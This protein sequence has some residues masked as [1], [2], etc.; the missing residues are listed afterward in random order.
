M[1][2]S[3]KNA[4][5]FYDKMLDLAST[6][7]RIINPKRELEGGTIKGPE[8]IVKAFYRDDFHISITNQ[9]QTGGSS[10]VKTLVDQASSFITGRV[11]KMATHYMQDYL[12]KA[13]SADNIDKD[14]MDWVDK[15]AS[16]ISDIQGIQNSAFF[17]ADDYFKSFKGTTVTFPTNI[18]LTLVSDEWNPDKENDVFYQ[19]KK[20]M[21]VSIGDYST[22]GIIG[23]VGIQSA[24]NDFRTGGMELKDD[25]KGTLVVVYGDPERGGYRIDNMV[26]SNLHFTF[27]KTK[28]QIGETT[29]EVEE[30][31]PDNTKTKKKVTTGIFR[32]LYIDIQIMLEPAQKYTK[33]DVK[34]TLGADFKSFFPPKEENDKVKKDSATEDKSV[35]NEEVQVEFKDLTPQEQEDYIERAIEDAIYRQLEA[36]G[37]KYR[38]K[39]ISVEYNIE[40]REL[41]ICG[42]MGVQ[43]G[44]G[45]LADE[46]LQ[47]WMEDNLLDGEKVKKINNEVSYRSFAHPSIPTYYN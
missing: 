38:D 8:T 14:G 12:G 21:D 11:G 39:D 2:E 10:I 6:T 26:I 34:D 47:E 29:N 7:V 32:P 28:V 1:A 46:D 25:V 24:P 40:T 41:N 45:V 15:T 5:F 37:D 13:K 9:W 3:N 30:T 42:A 23:W 33:E 43:R 44:A 22:D 35:E 17:T 19:L 36:E 20:L 27:S 16:I 18:Q 31:N 4:I